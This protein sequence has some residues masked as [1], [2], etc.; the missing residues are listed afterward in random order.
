[1]MIGVERPPAVSSFQRRFSPW[2]DHLS[3]MLCSRE[4]PF[5][6]GPLQYV[7]SIGSDANAGAAIVDNRPAIHNLLMRSDRLEGS[8]IIHLAPAMTMPGRLGGLMTFYGS[9]SAAA[10]PFPMTG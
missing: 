1:M 10:S 5:C 7:Q 4:T 8:S 6:S 2:G 3:T 9:P